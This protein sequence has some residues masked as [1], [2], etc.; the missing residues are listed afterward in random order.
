MDERSRT[1]VQ[2]VAL[3]CVFGLGMCFAL[4][5]SIGVKL[6]PRLKIDQGK[7]GTLISAF[8]FT[9]LIASLVVGV[10]VDKVGYK[11]VAIFGFVVTAVCIWILAGGKT[12]GTVI[13]PCLFLGF[14]A[15]AMN[16]VGNTLILR[17]LFEGKNPAAA[18]NLGNVFFGL[19]LFVTPLLVSF[20]FKKTTYEKAVAVLGVIVLVPVIFTFTAKFPAIQAGFSIGDAIALLKQPVVLIA[21]LTLFCYI[22]LE[23]SFCNWLAPYGKEIISRDFPNMDSSAVDASAQ[24]MLSIFAVAMMAGRLIASQIAMITAHGSWFIA[25][26]ALI[27]GLVILSMTKGSALWTSALAVC[28]G[29]AFAPC[30]PTIVG[31]T[32]T[33]HPENFASVFGIIFAVGLAGGVIVPKT[34]GNVARGASIQKSLKLLLPACVI[35]IVLAVILGK[36]KGVAG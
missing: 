35:L 24:Q 7:F 21:A 9:C 23:S 27:S 22:S 36:L 1:M 11:P 12:F 10:V 15:M 19:G 3:M 25:G 31:V 8:M 29:M 20:L 6:M 33:K 4:L 2:A 28:A 16:T 17:V 30:F 34:I 14:G 26:A 13:V 18:S 5:G 32:N